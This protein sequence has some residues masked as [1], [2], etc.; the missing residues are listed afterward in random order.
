[1]LERPSVE[2]SIVADF[3]AEG[4]SEPYDVGQTVLALISSGA[5]IRNQE[6]GA[7]VELPCRS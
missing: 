4:D 3:I 6:R 2:E 7:E 5:G 1:M